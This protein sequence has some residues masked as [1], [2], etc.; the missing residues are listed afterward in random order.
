[1]HY[2]SPRSTGLVVTLLLKALK[3]GVKIHR[4]QPDTLCFDCQ[5]PTTRAAGLKDFKCKAVA[6]ELRLGAGLLASKTHV[7]MTPYRHWCVK[8]K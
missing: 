6:L 4:Y 7:I 1:M 3:T 8:F 2:T 5:Y